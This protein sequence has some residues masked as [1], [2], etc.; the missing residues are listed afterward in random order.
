[1]AEV[2]QLTIY[3]VGKAATDKARGE[4][5][6]DVILSEVSFAQPT[7]VDATKTEAEIS[8][9]GEG[10]KDTVQAELGNTVEALWWNF[11]GIRVSPP[12]VKKDDDVLVLRLGD[13]DVYYW[14]DLNMA[15]VKRLECVVF[16]IN[17][18]PKS[19]IKQDLSNAYWFMMSSLDKSMHIHTSAANGEP[20]EWDIQLDTNESILIVQDSKGNTI[21]INSKEDDI[22][23]ENSVGTK[24]QLVKQQIFGYAEK[25]INFKTQ[26]FVVDCE[27]ADI[28]GKNKVSFNTPLTYASEKLNV[29]TDFSYGGVGEGKGNFTAPDAIIAGITFTVHTH[30]EQGDGKDVSVPH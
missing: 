14:L 11:N 22:G 30:T 26:S 29:G 15:N 21:Y 10:G 19:K 18:D 20:F 23:M 28:N 17:A 4:K 7:A 9:E 24:F 27:T 16:A 3:S 5:K 2:S 25:L 8:H 13:T 1:M 6:L 12:D